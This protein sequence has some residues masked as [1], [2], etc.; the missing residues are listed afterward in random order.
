M[1]AYGT[2]YLGGPRKVYE[3]NIRIAY[4][5]WMTPAD[6]KKRFEEIINSTKRNDES[7]YFDDD[8]GLDS[9]IDYICYEDKYIYYRFICDRETCKT[10]EKLRKYYE[11]QVEKTGGR[12][13]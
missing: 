8:E 3:V 12:W 11:F 10:L 5:Y 13:I 6:V 1:A 7:Y 2:S 9:I 4:Q